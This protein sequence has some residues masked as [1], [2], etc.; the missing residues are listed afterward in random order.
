MLCW[1]LLKLRKQLKAGRSQVEA[2]EQIK[3]L[4]ASLVDGLGPF[5][6]VDENRATA[7]LALAVS[8]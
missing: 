7:V 4:Q 8:P 3:G 1:G 5:P 2:Y 6:Y